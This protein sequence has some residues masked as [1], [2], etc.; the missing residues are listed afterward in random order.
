M[1]RKA[2]FTVR[3]SQP[4]TQQVQIDYVTVE[5]KDE[6]FVSAQ[7]IAADYSSIGSRFS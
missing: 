1:T 4:S 5:I 6:T 2:V 7:I 3:L